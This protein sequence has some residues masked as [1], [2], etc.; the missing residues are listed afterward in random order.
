MLWLYAGNLFNQSIDAD[1]YKPIRTKP[2][3]FDNKN[4]YIEYESEGDKD[5][6]LLP[7]KYLN[8]IRR[9][10]SD[11]INDHKSHGVLKVHS[12][13]KI[14][15]CKKISFTKNQEGLEE[16]MKGSE[17]IPDSVDL[18]HYQLHKTSLKSVRS[19]IDSPK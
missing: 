4:N 18:L 10:I 12:A 13:N 11:M 7:E 14:I 16:S 8:M 6:I 19:Y 5:K 9:Y 15:D 1:Y 3:G 17:F 2:N